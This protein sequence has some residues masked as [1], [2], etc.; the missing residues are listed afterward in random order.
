MECDPCDL[1]KHRSLIFASSNEENTPF[2]P[3]LELQFHSLNLLRSQIKQFLQLLSLQPLIEVRR[4][5]KIF[6]GY[7][8][9]HKQ[10]PPSPTLRHP[11][12][13]SIIRQKRL[14]QNISPPL[15]SKKASGFIQLIRLRC[16]D[17]PK[18]KYRNMISFC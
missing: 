14:L 13:T 5:K 15:I 9:V 12:K 18:K 11:P 2:H 4:T 16:R 6:L 1:N 3:S 17:R 8:N 10:R 7:R